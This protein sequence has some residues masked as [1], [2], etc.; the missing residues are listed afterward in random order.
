MN[1][2]LPAHPGA[3]AVGPGLRHILQMFAVADVAGLSGGRDGM[4]NDVMM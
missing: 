2:T 3:V 1:S 4:L